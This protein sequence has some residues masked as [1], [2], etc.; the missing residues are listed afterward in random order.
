MIQTSSSP[1]FIA[2]DNEVLLMSAQRTALTTATETHNSSVRQLSPF[3]AETR[4]Y[5]DP[6]HN[7]HA[8]YP[9]PQT[10]ELRRV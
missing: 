1:S 10:V 4:E 7:G 6:T 2:Y 8:L 9:A 3:T 5:L